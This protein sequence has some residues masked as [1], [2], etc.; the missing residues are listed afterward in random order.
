MDTENS[1]HT[2]GERVKSESDQGLERNFDILL[3]T[4]EAMKELGI[5]VK[6]PSSDEAIAL[7]QFLAD[8]V[9]DRGSTHTLENAL[10]GIPILSSGMARLYLDRGYKFSGFVDMKNVYGLNEVSRRNGDM[11]IRQFSTA[12]VA[13]FTDS[14]IVRWGGD[15]FAILSK[16][17]SQDVQNV[18]RKLVALSEEIKIVALYRKNGEIYEE[19]VNFSNKEP[20]SQLVEKGYAPSGKNL[21]QRTATLSRF[22]TEVNTFHKATTYRDEESYLQAT[23]LLEAALYH[24][25]LQNIAERIEVPGGPKVSIY[26]D[27]H[28]FLYHISTEIDGRYPE[29]EGKS[30]VRIDKPGILKALNDQ[31]AK[32]NYQAGDAFMIDQFDKQVAYLL[33]FPETKNLSFFARGTELNVFLPNNLLA[34][35]KFIEGLKQ[36]GGTGI[37]IGNTNKLI[38]TTVGIAQSSFE[39]FMGITVNGNEH[40]TEYAIGFLMDQAEK[41]TL[42]DMYSTIVKRII[43]DTHTSFPQTL[44]FILEYFSLNNK[45][46]PGRLAKIDFPISKVEQYYTFDEENGAWNLPDNNLKELVNDIYRHLSAT[47]EKFEN[48]EEITRSYQ[49]NRNISSE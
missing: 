26:K 15:E 4:K 39:D 8:H 41:S 1:A 46:G 6:N 30:L 14:K 25:K 20:E 3:K 38:I 9:F 37:Q 31:E 12:L 11:V 13:Q 24:P 34:N 28:D 40:P 44:D 49:M 2:E 22:H 23:T 47:I 18:Q 17:T 16:D 35:P 5:E 19:K 36:A 27:L 33:Q 42:I 29:V 43:T 45:R 32:G 10:S 21:D 48:E 7:T